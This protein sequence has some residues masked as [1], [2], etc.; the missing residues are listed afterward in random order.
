MRIY[1]IDFTSAPTPSKPLTCAQAEIRDG[2]LQV[3]TVHYWT[4]FAAFEAFLHSEGPWIAALDFP[5][6]LPRKLV[7]NLGWPESWD[8]CVAQVSRLKKA[9]FG[10]LLQAYQAARPKGDRHHLRQTDVRARARSPMMWYGVPVARMFFEG[11]QRL[12]RS[13]VCILPC[14]PNRDS[15]LVLEGYPAL[16]ARRWVGAISYKTERSNEDVL[17]KARRNALVRQLLSKQAER[18]YGLRVEAS[19]PLSRALI[20]DH[21]GDSLD[22]V[23]CAVQAAWAFTQREYR[24]GIPLE[25]DAIEGWIVDPSLSGCADG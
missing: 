5:F 19:R 4:D 13:N 21:L 18:Y 15:R 20:S 17:A 2:T 16:V 12:S 24:Y 6:G 25:C 11:V 7:R 1:G 10:Q 22:A 9:A 8:V 14:R 23:L 3:Q